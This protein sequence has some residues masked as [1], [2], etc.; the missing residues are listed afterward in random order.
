M[1]NPSTTVLL[2]FL[3]ALVPAAASA[4]TRAWLDRDR[5]ELG[6]TVTLNIETDG[7][8]RP[9]YA[10]LEQDFSIEQRS[11]RQGFEERGG[12]QVS[13]T[14]YAVALQPGRAGRLTVPAL[15][16]GGERTAP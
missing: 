6:E 13:R 10:P 5:I 9:D 16:V 7:P 14:L 1:M 15:R 11:S 3:L 2:A 4:E 8:D 12:R